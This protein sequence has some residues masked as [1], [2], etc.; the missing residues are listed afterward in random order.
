MSRGLTLLPHQIPFRAIS[1]VVR[2]D[3]RTAEGSF[4]C[5]A[6]DALTAAAVL[7]SMVYEAMAQ[8]AGSIVFDASSSSP[9]L[10]SGIRN[11]SIDAPFEPGDAVTIRATLEGDFEGVWGFRASAIRNGLECARARLYLASPQ[12]SSNAQN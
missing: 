4:L 7:D 5:S 2:V 6:N 8:V 9:A 3:D 11:A 12:K 10:L 1:A